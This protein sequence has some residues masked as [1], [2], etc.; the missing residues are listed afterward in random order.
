MVT[1]DTMISTI[2]TTTTVITVPDSHD[3]P[4]LYSDAHL[5]SAFMSL[6]TGSPFSRAWNQTFNTYGRQCSDTANFQQFLTHP[7]TDVHHRPCMKGF[8][9]SN[10]AKKIRNI[11]EVLSELRS[12]LLHDRLH[13]SVLRALNP[14]AN[15]LDL[16]KTNRFIISKTKYQRKMAK[17]TVSLQ[18]MWVLCR[19]YRHS[20]E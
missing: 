12:A 17:R 8:C 13:V 5:L 7:Q 19:M 16:S 20:I 3:I 2:N 9:W 6:K 4:I 18:Y 14:H 1:I 15:G 10:N 11:H